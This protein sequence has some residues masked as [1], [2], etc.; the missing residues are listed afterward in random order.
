MSYSTEDK[1]I[2]YSWVSL[3]NGHSEL[4]HNRNK[5][6]KADTV[7]AITLSEC[8]DYPLLFLYGDVA[9]FVIVIDNEWKGR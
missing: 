2:R 4:R 5:H 8:E 9:I 7:N 1:R 3:V 6:P